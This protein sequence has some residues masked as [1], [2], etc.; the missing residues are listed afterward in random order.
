MTSFISPYSR[1]DNFWE[2]G[3]GPK[4]L[5]MLSA[6]IPAILLHI[7]VIWVFLFLADSSSRKL[8]P[9]DYITVQLL[10]ELMPA[11]PAAPPAPVDKNIKTPDVV[12]APKSA[13]DIA[14]PF[15]PSTPE[16][17]TAPPEVI[18]LGPQAKE[19]PPEI[20]KA[21]PK[22]V[23]TPPKV[24]E[25][26]PPK[27]VEPKPNPDAELNKSL[28]ALQRK[29]EAQKNQDA[30]GTHVNT[31]I[32][33]GAG[34][35]EGSQNSGST[36]GARLDPRI[37]SYYNHLR[38]II[39]QNW[40]W[41]SPQGTDESKLVTVVEALIEPNGVIKLIKIVR[42]S[43]NQDFDLSVIKAINKSNPFPALPPVF[44]GR[45]HNVTLR[46]RPADLR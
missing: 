16:V 8:G 43:G 26:P 2:S 14:Q 21:T 1:R 29:V 36:D 3:L 35:G 39:R 7:A 6:G 34:T 5:L 46:F 9:D 45:S 23:V 40:F 25:D 33:E 22:P 12:E 24:R 44:E 38:D 30:Q 37:A 41:V 28:A 13:P 17:I 32:S 20:K 42:P 11:A 19:K 27:K 31:A 15:T 4:I 10:G 18:P